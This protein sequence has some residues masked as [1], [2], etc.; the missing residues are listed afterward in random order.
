MC[1]HLWAP[2]CAVQC[3]IHYVNSHSQVSS[4]YTGIWVQD[5]RA[6]FQSQHSLPC[7]RL[8]NFLAVPLVPL[9][10]HFSFLTGWWRPHHG[11]PPDVP[12]KEHQRC[13]GLH[14]WH[15]QA[16]PAQLRLTSSQ[17]G[18]HAV[19]SSLLFPILFTLLQMLQISYT[20]EQGRGG[21]GRSALLLPRYCAWCLD[22]RL[23]ASDRRSLC[24]T[25]A[26][27]GKT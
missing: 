9:L 17:P 6:W 13:L 22:A 27:L 15:V 14:Q 23:V 5:S 16:C 19:S 18:T 11:V 3:F 10:N 2:V 8:L 1:C 24:C 12:I 26:C 21:S 7:F 4:V 25:S 20:N